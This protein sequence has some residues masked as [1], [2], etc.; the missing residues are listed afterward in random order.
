[1]ETKE[2]LLLYKSALKKLL[3]NI[4]VIGVTYVLGLCHLATKVLN[5]EEYEIFDKN[6]DNY[7][8]SIGEDTGHFLWTIG[9]QKTREEWLKQ[10]LEKVNQKLKIL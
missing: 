2:E 3:K 8:M 9:E 4:P 7:A 1:M 5:I 10:E 6:I